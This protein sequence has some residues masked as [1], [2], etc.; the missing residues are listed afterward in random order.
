MNSPQALAAVSYFLFTIIEDILWHIY[1]TSTL[2]KFPDQ[3]K[4]AIASLIAGPSTKYHITRFRGF[5]TSE[6]VS[7][8]EKCADDCFEDIRIV[9]DGG[10]TFPVAQFLQYPSVRFYFVK[11][12]VFQFFSAQKGEKMVTQFETFSGFGTSGVSK[13]DQ[14]GCRS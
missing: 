7:F 2:F 10:T 12:H 4:N 3:N 8:F 14:H 11:D 5:I 6:N 1:H 13:M 9:S